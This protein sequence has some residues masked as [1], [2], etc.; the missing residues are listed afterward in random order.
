MCSLIESLPTFEHHQA[1]NQY[2]QHEAIE[3]AEDEQFNSRSSTARIDYVTP[4]PVNAEELNRCVRLVQQG[5]RQDHVNAP[6]EWQVLHYRR[7][8]QWLWDGNRDN[9]PYLHSKNM[10]ASVEKTKIRMMISSGS[11]SMNEIC[12]V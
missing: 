7:D 2:C 5:D 12:A 10:M 9:Y 4:P 11:K 1:H 8:E 3:E 6:E